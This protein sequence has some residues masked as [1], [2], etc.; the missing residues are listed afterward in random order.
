MR[1]L[2]E[3]RRLLDALDRRVDE[4]Y[5]N[6]DAALYRELVASPPKALSDEILNFCES[7]NIR[8]TD[9]RQEPDFHL[10]PYYEWRFDLSPFQKPGY[11]IEYATTLQISKLY[12]VFFLRHTFKLKDMNPNATQRFLEGEGHAS[13]PVTQTQNTLADAIAN[14]LEKDSF[15]KLRKYRA[16]DLEIPGLAFSNYSRLGDSRP[17]LLATYYDVFFRCEFDELLCLEYYY[18]IRAL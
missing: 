7:K 9:R 10:K 6:R 18:D 14:R 17:P 1:A 4:I 12:D 8:I 11:Y 3:G 2:K 13:G 15:T 16:A 5:G